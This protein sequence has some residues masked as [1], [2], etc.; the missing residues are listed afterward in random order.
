MAPTNRKQQK[1]DN[2]APLVKDEPER[3]IALWKDI[4]QTWDRTE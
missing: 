2:G 3:V 4:L 1:A